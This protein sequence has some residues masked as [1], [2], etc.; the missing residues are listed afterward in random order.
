[1]QATCCAG[2]EIVQGGSDLPAACTCHTSCQGSPGTTT[3]DKDNKCTTGPPS[4]QSTDS[5]VDCSNCG[6]GSP[7][8]ES[9]ETYFT[10]FALTSNIHVDYATECNDWGYEPA[11]EEASSLLQTQDKSKVGSNCAGTGSTDTDGCKCP[12]DE[13]A[14]GSWSCNRA[15]HLQYGAPG[16]GTSSVSDSY[17]IAA[18]CGHSSAVMEGRELRYRCMSSV[19]DSSKRRLHSSRPTICSAC[20]PRLPGTMPR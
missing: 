10:G 19:A 1:M 3:C 13:G 17:V 15:W 18:M 16:C 5:G 12:A 8:A 4:W 7:G 20:W 14:P 2:K 6:D 9:T 11:S